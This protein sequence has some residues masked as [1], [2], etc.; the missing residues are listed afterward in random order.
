MRLVGVVDTSVVVVQGRMLE[1]GVETRAAH[2]DT[3]HSY[4]LH[5]PPNGSKSRQNPGFAYESRM[6]LNHLP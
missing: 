4:C 3:G 2:T 6:S 5:Y 1:V